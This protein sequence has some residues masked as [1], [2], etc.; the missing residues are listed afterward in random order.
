MSPLLIAATLTITL[1]FLAYTVGAFSERRAGTLKRG[2]L[3][4]AA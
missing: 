2:H 4:A 1:A 3:A